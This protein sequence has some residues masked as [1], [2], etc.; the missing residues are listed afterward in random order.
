MVSSSSA[1]AVAARAPISQERI[2]R[3]FYLLAGCLLLVIVAMGFQKFYLHG[4][5]STGEPV[6]QQIVPLV[7]LHGVAMSA[8]II[9]F[10]VQS[11]LIVSGNRKLHMSLGIVGMVLAAFLVIV[12]VTTAMASVHYNP[13]GY[14]DLW[15]ARRFLSFMLTNIVGFGML[16]AMG[17]K[18]RRRPEIH[19]PMMLLATLFVAGPA[20]FFRIPFIS[21]P[22]M[23]AI[24][25]IFAPWVPMLILGV[26]LV[27]IKRLMTRTWDQ[28]LMVG[29]AGIIVACVL[30]AWVA[31]TSWW[32]HVAG[33]VTA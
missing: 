30:Q 12:G 26:F 27:L 8:W 10:V 15:S 22:I 19:R 5:A 6:T 13:D 17:L 7:F 21:G 1:V 23:A 18:F 25:T 29:F 2:E 11:S 16:A 4:R 31:N 32:Y 28:Y 20:A 3:G 9:A 24:H 14:K 33:W